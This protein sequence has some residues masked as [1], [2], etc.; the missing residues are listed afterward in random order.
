MS[1]SSNLLKHTES[2]GLRK[3]LI[4]NFNDR[5]IG[6]VGDG[7]T[8]LDVGCGEGF[9]LKLVSEKNPNIQL[10]GCD[11]S[12]AAIELAK[13]QVPK[14]NLLVNN[15]YRIDFLDKSFET[16]IC[17]EVL[18]HV[19]EPE[20]MLAEISRLC[21]GE[22][23]FSV[24]HEPWFL[25]GNL[26]SGKYLKTFGNHP[27]HIQHFTKAKFRRL[28]NKYFEEIECTTN[29]PWIIYRGRIKEAKK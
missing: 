8:L 23:L 18:E 2:R 26:A 7:A 20:Q 14:A 1:Q 24:P 17:S 6:M 10:A 16:V 25:L 12:Q 11:I 22:V 3:K 19:P 29:F 13:Q 5:F 28:C 9:T 21:N 27:E 15:G 4:D